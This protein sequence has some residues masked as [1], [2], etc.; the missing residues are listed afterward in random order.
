VSDLK[1]VEF[2][3]VRS[4]SYSTFSGSGEGCC[5]LTL[6]FTDPHSA[7]YR[8][9]FKITLP[10]LVANPDFLVERTRYETSIDRNWAHR[11]KCLVWWRNEDGE[12]GSWW[13]GRI[14]AVKPKSSK[15]PDSPW[16][17]YLF[18]IHLCMYK[19]RLFYLADLV[20]HNSRSS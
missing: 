4:L 8:N 20:E 19:I 16:E 6:E 15:F 10:E 13:E 12:S 18:V 2:C 17:R 14:M 1:A 7:A 5:K 3:K 9:L 11:D